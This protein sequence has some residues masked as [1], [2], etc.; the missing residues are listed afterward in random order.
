VEAVPP[1]ALT[2]D[3]RFVTGLVR[4]AGRTLIIL[5]PRTILFDEET[6]ALDTALQAASLR[7]AGA[8]SAP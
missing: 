4:A 2:I 5:N 3:S 6:E 1:V 8:E 7:S